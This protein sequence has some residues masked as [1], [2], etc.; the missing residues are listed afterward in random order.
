MASANYN[1]LNRGEWVFSHCRLEHATQALFAELVYDWGLLN[2][3]EPKGS[4][5]VFVVYAAMTVDNQ[6]FWLF[7]ERS[8]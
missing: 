5:I 3:L 4:G 6:N 1:Q 8:L 7:L 2:T